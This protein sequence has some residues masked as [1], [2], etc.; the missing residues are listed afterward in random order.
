MS[1]LY[2]IAEQFCFFTNRLPGGGVKKLMTGMLTSAT[3]KEKPPGWLKI[4]CRVRRYSFRG[5]PVYAIRA[6]RTAQKSGKAVLFLHG[7]GGM[8]RP[9]ALHYDT[10]RRIASQTGAVILLP[11]YPL[12]PSHTVRDALRWLEDLYRALCRKYNTKDIVFMGD[13]A[14]ANL[15]LSLAGRSADKPSGLIIISPAFGL[16]DG[17]PRDIRLRAE[18]RDPVLSVEMNDLIAANWCR[19]IPL[20]SPDISPEFVDYTGFPPMLFI[21]GTHEL[22]Y[23]HVK[24]GIRKIRER[25]A[26]IETF[27]RALCHDFALCAFFREGRE[28]I[29]KMSEWINRT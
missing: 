12:A 2:D 6:K 23:P 4:A 18:K 10:A 14:G 9:T 1:L 19:G 3:G 8:S 27:G 26:D 24:K 21:Y 5:F 13:S 7:G 16:Q 29:R 11:F 22:F 17:K 28:A 15:C 25:G 20:D